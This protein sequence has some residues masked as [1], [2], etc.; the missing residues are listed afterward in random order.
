MGTVDMQTAVSSHVKMRSSLSNIFFLCICLA[1]CAGQESEEGLD[2]TPPEVRRCPGDIFVQSRNCSDFVSW[3]EPE[4]FDS[5]GIAGII[6]PPYSQSGKSGGRTGQSVQCGTTHI[7]YIA[8]DFANNIAE[9]SFRIF[10]HSEFCPP[11][12][13]PEG[14]TQQC[15]FWGPGG[16]FMVCRIQ[17]DGN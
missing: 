2:N 16:R 6:K 9:C 13:P 7:S 8:S 10:V 11:L 5:N 17:C 1:L 4:F 12:K 3:D 15:D 14:G